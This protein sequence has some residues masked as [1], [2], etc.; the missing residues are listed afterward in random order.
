LPKRNYLKSFLFNKSVQP[1]ISP[2]LLI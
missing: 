2:R 1:K